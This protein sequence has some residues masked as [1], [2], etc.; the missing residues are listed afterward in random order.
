MSK[1]WM[2]AAIAALLVAGMGATNKSYGQAFGV[3]LQNNL[4]PASGGMG[5]TSIARPQDI[6][7]AL[8]GNPATLSQKEGTQF[9][10]S[11]AWAEPTINFENR[12]TIAPANVEPFA[13]K[14]QRPGSIVGN[15]AATQDYSAKGLPVTLGIG[16]LTSSGLGVNYRDVVESNG[17]TAELVVLATGV[18]AGVRLTDKLSVGLTGIVST[19]N[20]DG[21][22]TGITAVTPNY[23]MRG[24]FGFTYDVTPETTVGGFWHTK[25]KHTFRDFVRIGGPSAPFQDV[26]LEFPNAYGLGVANESLLGGRL[27]LAADFA[28][29]AWSDADLFGAIWDDQFTF[30]TGAQ[31]T[32]DRG[33]KFRFGYAY[34]ENASANVVAP[35]IGGVTPQAGVDYLQALFP[36]INEHRISGGLG[37]ELLPGLEMDLF[38][39]GMFDATQNF[40][41]SSVSAESYWIGFG[42]TWKFGRGGCNQC[43]IPTVW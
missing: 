12:E 4:M 27:L 10:F 37:F 6:Q 25:E 5:G 14:S 13:P 8:G 24:L 39:G 35:T 41:N 22:F 16:L 26:D 1:T 36:N 20:L 7:S 31:F 23:N 29:F 30:Q 21:V 42:S 18:G 19:A 40:Q 38:A 17:T 28:Y 15:I 33:C 43:S 32:T 34:A 3:A 2:V 9:S 11:G